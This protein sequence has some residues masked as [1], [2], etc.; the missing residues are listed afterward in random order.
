MMVCGEI[1]RQHNWENNIEKIEFFINNSDTGINLYGNY[2]LKSQRNTC[3][4]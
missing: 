4:R 2:R 1:E 3:Q